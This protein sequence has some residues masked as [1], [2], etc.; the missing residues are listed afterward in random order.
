MRIYCSSDAIFLGAYS[1]G[2]VAGEPGLHGPRLG[3]VELHAARDSECTAE[4][5]KDGWKEE[6]CISEHIY[7]ILKSA[8]A[9]LSAFFWRPLTIFRGERSSRRRE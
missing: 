9:S 6:D 3:S 2:E 5:E 4:N 8:G 7:N 1:E